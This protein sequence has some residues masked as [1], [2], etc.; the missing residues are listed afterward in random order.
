MSPGLRLLSR[1][2]EA[3]LCLGQALAAGLTPG[4]V[5][6]LHGDL[7]TGKT[8]LSRGLARGLGISEP[9]T[10]PTFSV[11]QEYPRA[12]GTFLFHLDLYRISGV[13]A[14]LAFGIEEYLFAL[15]GITVIEWPERIEGLLDLPGGLRRTLRIHLSHGADG[16]RRI[17]LPDDL[18]ACV[19]GLAAATPGLLLQE[20]AG[21]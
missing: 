15:D 10:S 7:G 16:G 2:A 12:D 8:V 9:V 6:A 21:E 17:D 20:G 4:V 1:S 3:T 19:R 14:A 5:L 11:V 13:A 18:A